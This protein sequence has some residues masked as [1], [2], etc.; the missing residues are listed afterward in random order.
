VQHRRGALQ[1]C[2]AR[3]LA[4]APA[5]S[6]TVVIHWVITASGEVAE[7]CITEDTV[8]DRELTACVNQLV[9][10]GG[11]PA[12]TGGAVD[13]SF[14]FVFTARPAVAAR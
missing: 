4:V 10:A 14:P 2:Y 8:G 12:P 6:G 11:F 7:A 5:L 9:A 13:V 1:Q 3:R